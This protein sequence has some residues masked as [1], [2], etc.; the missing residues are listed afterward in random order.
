MVL[1]N[2]STLQAQETPE[3]MRMPE[4]AEAQTE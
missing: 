3:S 4:G 1:L 2:F